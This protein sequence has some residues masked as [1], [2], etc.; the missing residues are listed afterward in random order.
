MSL[1]KYKN[2]KGSKE[3]SNIKKDTVRLLK[4]IYGKVLLYDVRFTQFNVSAI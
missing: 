3:I 2:Q 1:K 4:F